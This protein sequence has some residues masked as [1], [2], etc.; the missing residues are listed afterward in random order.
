MRQGEDETL[1][2]EL[3]PAGAAENLMGRTR[4]D[5]LLF[6][7]F[8]FQKAR[9][10]DRSRRQIDPRSQ[11]FRADADREQLFLEQVFDNPLVLRQDSRVMHADAAHQELLQLRADA[12]GPIVL[13]ELGHELLLLAVAEHLPAFEFLG[14]PP[15][16]VAVEAEDER[17]RFALFGALPGPCLPVAR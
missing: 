3:R 5:Q 6:A 4:V 17:R 12:F 16:F 14:G 10:H 2:V 1:L 9:Q 8:P 15:A 11:R 13:G 7:G